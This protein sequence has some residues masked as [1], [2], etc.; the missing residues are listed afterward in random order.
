M[1]VLGRSWVC[2]NNQIDLKLHFCLAKARQL[3]YTSMRSKVEEELDK[4]EGILEHAVI[5][6]ADW[7]CTHCCSVL[8]RGEKKTIQI[9]G[10]VKGAET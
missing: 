2:S 1:H 3:P 10:T 6:Y 4:Y 7:A 5:K 9:C 8:I